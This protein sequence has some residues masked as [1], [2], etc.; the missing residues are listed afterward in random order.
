MVVRRV[1][2]CMD[3]ARGFPVKIPL[4]LSLDYYFSNAELHTLI[5]R[6]NHLS[7]DSLVILGC[8]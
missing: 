4:C 6:F 8:L 2:I 7:E 3:M 5:W 1:G